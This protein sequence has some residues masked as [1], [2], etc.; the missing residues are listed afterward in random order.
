MSAIIQLNDIHKDYKVAVR[1]KNLIHYIFSRQYDIVEALKGISFSINKGELVGFIGPNGAGKSTTI[2]LL[3]GILTKSKG[4]ISVLGN[5]PFKKR[6]QNMYHIGVVFGQRSQLWWDLPLSD[7][8]QLLKKIYKVSD[9][10]YNRSM[11]LLNEHFRLQEIWSKPVRQLSLGQRMRGEIA[12]AVLHNPDILFLDEPTIGLDV[13]AKREIREF[14]RNLNAENGTTILLTS[15]DTKDIEEICKR[16]IIIDKGELVV[17][18]PKSLFMEEFNQDMV[19]HI[20]FDSQVK[21]MD[22]LHLPVIMEGSG[23]EWTFRYPKGTVSLEV[24][25]HEISKL[26]RIVNVRIEEQSLENIIYEIYQR[27]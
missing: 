25:M 2:K 20:E 24:L 10:V 14:I 12:S 9:S 16:I 15:H 1:D 6:K 22:G 27:K 11:D 4:E 5:D 21:T 19:V 18:K 26:H 23:Y 13:V 7:T 17:D 3:C 8:F